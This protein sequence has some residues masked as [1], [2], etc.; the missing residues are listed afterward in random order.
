MDTFVCWC[1]SQ[2]SKPCTVAPSLFQC[3]TCATLFAQPLGLPAQALP[4]KKIVRLTALTTPKLS[5]PPDEENEFYVKDFVCSCGS[6]IFQPSR[7]DAGDLRRCTRCHITFDFSSAPPQKVNWF[8]RAKARQQA[9]L[10]EKADAGELV[11]IEPPPKT[12]RSEILDYLP[13]HRVAG[14]VK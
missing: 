13:D 12:K 14:R 11:S 1:G 8:E 9:W 6:Q 2:K 4:E 7:H 10:Q 3:C 5:S